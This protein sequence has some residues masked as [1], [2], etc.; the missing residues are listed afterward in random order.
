MQPDLINRRAF[1]ARLSALA[2]LGVIDPTSIDVAQADQRNEVSYLRGPYNTAFFHRH[3]EAY[4]IGSGIHFSHGKQHDVLL[5]TKFADHEKWDAEFNRESLSRVTGKKPQTEPTMEYYAPYSERAIWQILRAI[6]WTHD[7][8]EQT[9][10]IM[11]SPRIAWADKARWT[12]RS[13]DYYLSKEKKGIPRSVAPLDVTMRRAA[14]MMKPYFTLFR[15]YYPQSNDFFFGA[16]WWHPVIYEAQ[17]L[18]GNSSAQVQMVKETDATYYRD[19]LNDRPLRMHFSR[20]NMPRYARMAP[21]AANA[22]DNLHMLH[23]FVYDCLAYEGW[24]VEQKQEELYRVLYAMSNQPGDEKL[25]RK[26]PLPHPEVDPRIYYPW[27]KSDEGEM[28][29]IMMEMMMEM[30]PMMMP[31]MTDDMRDKMMAQFKLK[32]MPGI[33]EGELPG[34]LHD[35][36]MK[37]MP[38]MKMMPGSMEPGQTPQ[39]MVDVMLKGWQDK[40]GSM[41]DVPPYPMDNEPT[42]APLLGKV[43]PAL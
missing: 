33:Q 37:M 24:T 25:T 35:A 1:V 19:V 23:G 12:K 3:N 7:L 38:D 43:P 28:S 17:M 42:E 6:D 34:S 18:G 13:M 30:M 21:E 15:N 39:M 36:L 22:F 41:P 5:L 9:Y 26:F 31:N 40:Y 14:V 32:M 27:M 10:D 2:M 29:R 20:E 4:R 11:A 8:H 16:H